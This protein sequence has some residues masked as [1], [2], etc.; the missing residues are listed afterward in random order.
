[1]QIYMDQFTFADVDQCLIFGYAISDFFFTFVPLQPDFHFKVGQRMPRHP[2]FSPKANLLTGW[3]VQYRS[4]IQIGCFHRYKAV[5]IT[6][7]SQ[8]VVRCPTIPPQK[9]C[10][11]S[12]QCN[13][14]VTGNDGYPFTQTHTKHS[15]TVFSYI[16]LRVKNECV[17][18]NMGWCQNLNTMFITVA[19]Y[20]P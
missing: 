17:C 1:M 13:G 14:K 2:A 12:N 6:S 7:W 4:I 10:G 19:F 18:P 8:R 15:S 3:P 16:V 5:N 11:K 20:Y 9:C